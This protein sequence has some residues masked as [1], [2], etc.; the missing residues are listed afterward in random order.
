MKYVDSQA[1]Q[2]LL[3]EIQS[4]DPDR[5]V[6]ASLLLGK[7]D[8]RKIAN[9]NRESIEQAFGVLMR[10]EQYRLVGT[11][12]RSFAILGEEAVPEIQKAAESK[13]RDVKLAMCRLLL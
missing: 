10:T 9:S 13:E 7:T 8:V 4:S 12:A 5:Q 3:N 11:A 1:L 2:S 6:V